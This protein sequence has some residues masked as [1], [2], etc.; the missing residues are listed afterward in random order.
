MCQNPSPSSS[1]NPNASPSEEEQSRD[2]KKQAQVQ[3]LARRLADGDA[4]ARV[5]AARDIRKLARASAKARSAFA[6]AAVVQPL[7][8]M[9]PSPDPEARE[10]ALLALLNLAV[11]NER[12]KDKIVKSGAVPHLI[13]LL[14]S[15]NSSLRELATAAVLTLSASPSNKPTITSS[16]AVPLLVQILISGSIQGKVDAVTALYNLSTCKESLNLALPVEAVKP[17]LTLLKDSKKYSKFAEKA[18]ALLEI[19]SKTGE[20]ASSISEFDEGILTLVETI[21]EG[22]LLSTEYAVGVLLSLCRSCWV[23]YRELILNEGAI[24]G[25]LL[26]T[27]EG[28][29]KAQRRARELL[30]LLRDNS[31]PKRVAS[32][33]L[34]TIVYDIATRV[35]G[36]VKAAETAKR[37]LQDM[38]KRN[39][40]LSM[41]RLQH[42]AA[43]CTPKAP[44]T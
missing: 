25:L 10:S 27:V 19:I 20:G 23:K 7:V 17:L 3:E 18:A 40:E 16:G 31:R 38:V 35:D 9:L 26:L 39:M 1:P 34:E 43:S 37:L 44:M 12:N 13:E 21:E 42:R 4:A 41:T 36:P 5:Q 33:N 11:R 22:S 30:D 29:D 14:R 28:T 8:S 6:V 15:E 32:E 2:V 24:P